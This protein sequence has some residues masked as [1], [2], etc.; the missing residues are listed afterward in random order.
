MEIDLDDEPESLLD[1]LNTW[2]EK[3][4]VGELSKISGLSRP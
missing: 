4:V 1:S 2:R 3:V